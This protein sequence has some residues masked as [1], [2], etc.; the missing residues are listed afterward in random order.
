MNEFDLRLE[1]ELAWL[2]N[3]IVATP[4]PV[5]RQGSDRRRT[6]DAQSPGQPMPRLGLVAVPVDSLS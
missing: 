4:P 1:S 5:R 2:L 3:P 6:D